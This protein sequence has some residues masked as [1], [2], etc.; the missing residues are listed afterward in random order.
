MEVA[1]WRLPRPFPPSR[2]LNKSLETSTSLIRRQTILRMTGSGNPGGLLTCSGTISGRSSYSTSQ[3]PLM[4]LYGNFEDASHFRPTNPASEPDFGWRYINFQPVTVNTHA[5][6]KYLGHCIH[7]VDFSLDLGNAIVSTSLK[8]DCTTLGDGFPY[9]LLLCGCRGGQGTMCGRL[10]AGATAGAS[11]ANVPR[12]GK[13]LEW[14]VRNARYHCVP[15]LWGI[16]LTEEIVIC[17]MILHK[18]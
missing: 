4:I 9:C 16:S 18:S 1:G 14:C 5:V 17:M 6:N 7:Q 13:W 11:C 10:Q 8:S 15:V 2:G 3:F 12:K